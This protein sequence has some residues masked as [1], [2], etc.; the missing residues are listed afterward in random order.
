MV[1]HSEPSRRRLG[2][3]MTRWATSDARGGSVGTGHVPFDACRR[4]PPCY[5]RCHIP[6]PTPAAHVTLFFFLRL[7][8]ILFFLLRKLRYFF[9]ASH[10]SVPCA[11]HN[12]SSCLAIGFIA[13]HPVLWRLWPT[14]LFPS[15]T[16]LS[17]RF[18]PCRFLRSF[19]PCALLLLFSRACAEFL[20]LFH[21]TTYVWAPCTELK[22][23][24]T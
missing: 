19:V 24:L 6:L 17:Q 2:S 11:A 1:H 21:A 7:V 20:R 14:F 3:W 13:V 22:Y 9:L 18:F 12:V 10:L 16:F 4:Q 23:T 15:L 5:S 8:S